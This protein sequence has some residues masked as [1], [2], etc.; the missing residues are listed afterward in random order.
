MQAD[1]AVRSIDSFSLFRNVSKP[2]TPRQLAGLRWRVER[3]KAP[4]ADAG[5]DQTVALGQ[6]VTLDGG[7]SSDANGD[8]LTFRWSLEAP[9]GSAARLST[10]DT[11]APSFVVDR[12]GTYRATLIASDGALDSGPDRVVI[13][14]DNSRP[15]ADA[16]DD[17]TA[18]VGEI[19]ALDG[20]GSHDADGDPLLPS[21]SFTSVPA[22]STASLSDPGALKPTFPA[23]R[24]GLYVAQLLVRAGALT[25]EPDTVTIEVQDIAGPSPPEIDD[26]SPKRAPIGTLV[27]VT[28]KNFAPPGGGPAIRLNKRGG[29]PI[30]APLASFNRSTLRFTIPAA[31]TTGPIG[32][33]VG[34][35]SATSDEPIT[36][37]PSSGFSGRSSRPRPR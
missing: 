17:R 31:A 9:E 2:L 28:G 25:S 29:G 37:V 8:P 20:S 24:A 32:L 27:T 23:D 34:G 16:G 11:V 33:T 15:V 1:R 30:G 3:N 5:P 4:V 26:F 14:T 35:Q 7:G 36:V 12:P 18:Q 13:S 21:W 10:L 19:V 22:G 6:A